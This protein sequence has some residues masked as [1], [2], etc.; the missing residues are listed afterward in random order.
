MRRGTIHPTSATGC[1]YAT[2]RTLGCLLRF[3]TASQP[4]SYFAFPSYE[5]R[6]VNIE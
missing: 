5:A 6:W 2:Q 1:V 4:R 3:L